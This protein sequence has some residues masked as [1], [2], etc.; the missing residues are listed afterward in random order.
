VRD[1]VP[2]FRP[3]AT[4]VHKSPIQELRCIWGSPE[5]DIVD[6]DASVL[7]IDR[8]AEKEAGFMRGV[9]EIPVVI[10]GADHAVF[11]RLF[12]QPTIERQDIPRIIPRVHEIAGMHQN[13]SIGKT[14]YPDD[15]HR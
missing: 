12:S 4:R 10:A 13:I 2:V 15:T 3:Q 9:L 1:V 14:L 8:I 5:C 7:K 6:R 11:E